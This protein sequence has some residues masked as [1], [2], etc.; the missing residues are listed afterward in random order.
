MFSYDGPIGPES[1]TTR[2][3]RP[4]H[5][6]AAPPAKYAMSD[7]ILFTKALTL[8]NRMFLMVN[9]YKVS[10]IDLQYQT[11]SKLLYLCV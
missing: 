9:C 5:Q 2:M 7:C 4:V 10:D 11:S 8:Q 6:V 1:T 3:F